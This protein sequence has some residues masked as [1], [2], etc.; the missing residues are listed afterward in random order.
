MIKINNMYNFNNKK[1]SLVKEMAYTGEISDIAY[2]R[3]K[4]GNRVFIYQ[5]K[6]DR[7][8]GYRIYQDSNVINYNPATHL[9]EANLIQKLHE[10]GKNVKKTIFPYGVVTKNG[11][12]IGQAMPYYYNEISLTDA[13]RDGNNPYT[14]FL[15]ALDLIKELY[16]N[17]I[18]YIDIHGGNFLLTPTGLKLID[19]EKEAIAFKDED[20][21]DIAEGQMILDFVNMVKKVTYFKALSVIPNITKVQNLCDLEQ[22]LLLGE[23]LTLKKTL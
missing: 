7:N 23:A 5:D 16:D 3:K 20:M 18:I 9:E 11:N 2:L 17:G 6:L 13:A 10:Y 1:Y 8:I 22:E 14:L 21:A 12:V 15:E 19:F 4:A